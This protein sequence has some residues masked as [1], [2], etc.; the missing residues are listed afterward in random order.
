VKIN[1]GKK[2]GGKSTGKKNGDKNIRKK[3]TGTKNT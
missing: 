1:T 2:V 3:S